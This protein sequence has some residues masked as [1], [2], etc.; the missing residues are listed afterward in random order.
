MVGVLF[1]LL[2][3]A[4]MAVGSGANFTSQTVNTGNLV[5]AG[6]LTAAG[7]NSA[8]LNTGTKLRPTESV[9]G[10]AT[11]QNTG[12]T[13]G[14]FSVT[15]KNLVDT[16]GSA[17]GPNLSSQVTVT[18]QELSGPGGSVT[19]TISSGTLLSN[20]NSAIA[21]GNINGGSSRTYKFTVTFP[22]TGSDATDNT[23]QGAQ[24]ALNLQFD[25]V[26]S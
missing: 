18:V 1:A 12:N 22:T 4:A 16:P 10:E 9:S 8:I 19:N 5:A 21:L 17:G 15:G 13:R 2:L 20:F 25:A 11:I 6:T 7:P 14:A 26:Q 24:S 23:F 3:A